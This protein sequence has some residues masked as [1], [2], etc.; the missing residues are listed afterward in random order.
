M[1]TSRISERYTVLYWHRF[2]PALHN[3][4]LCLGMCAKLA[5]DRNSALG[6]NIQASPDKEMLSDLLRKT[7]EHT[8]KR[9]LQRE[10]LPI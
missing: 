8:S 4:K 3:V 6:V 2:H 9:E 10:L 5:M 7:G 1:P